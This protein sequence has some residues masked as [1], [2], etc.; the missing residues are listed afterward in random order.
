[1][2]ALA[3]LSIY[4]IP[5][6]RCLHCYCFCCPAIPEETTTL[7]SIPCQPTGF[8]VTLVVEAAITV[9][10]PFLSIVLMVIAI[11]AYHKKAS[12]WK[13]KIATSVT[14]PGTT[15]HSTIYSVPEDVE[16]VATPDTVTESK[17]HDLTDHL[18]ENSSVQSKHSFHLWQRASIESFVSIDEPEAKCDHLICKDANHAHSVTESRSHDLKTSAGPVKTLGE[19]MPENQNQHKHDKAGFLVASNMTDIQGISNFGSTQEDKSVKSK[20]VPS[21]IMSKKSSRPH[22]QKSLN[23]VDH[24]YSI[25]DQVSSPVIIE[26]IFED[27]DKLCSF[28]TKNGKDTA[29]QDGAGV[30]T[31]DTVGK[32]RV[33]ESHGMDYDSDTTA[34]YMDQD[35][36]P[37]IM[38]IFS[39]E[40][41]TELNSLSKKGAFSTTDVQERHK[42][43]GESGVKLKFSISEGHDVGT[44]PKRSSGIPKIVV[45]E[46]VPA[47]RARPFSSVLDVR[48]LEITNK[49]HSQSE[50]DL[51]LSES[52]RPA[53]PH[54]KHAWS[55]S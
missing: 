17:A 37:R 12:R 8:I 52:K 43:L 15:I 45:L 25:M 26:T 54:L 27:Q 9:F 33:D 5:L 42:Y 4:T 47:G 49:L 31:T 3:I 2:T 28:S 21:I 55:Q 20:S 30:A 50:G 38:K 16:H 51:V 39:D 14:S 29:V 48:S 41:R 19:V 35:N 46:T 23:M 24:G 34:T 40:R 53:T 6:L 36:S 22:D 13:R 11:V 10:S 1:M 18:S 7:V 32:R 44:P